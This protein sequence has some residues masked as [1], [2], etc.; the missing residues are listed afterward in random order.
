MCFGCCLQN[1]TA[2]EHEWAYNFVVAEIDGI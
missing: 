2:A 1:K